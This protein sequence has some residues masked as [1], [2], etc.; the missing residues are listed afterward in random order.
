MIMYLEAKLRFYESNILLINL[1]ICVDPL[2]ATRA[3]TA[4]HGTSYKSTHSQA[5]IL[6]LQI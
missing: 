3:N 2:P 6:H 5:R 4:M 1:D